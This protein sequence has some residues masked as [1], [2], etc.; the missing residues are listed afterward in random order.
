MQD[1]DHIIWVFDV[2]ELL[3]T[4]GDQFFNLCEGYY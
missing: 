1:L 3:L 2:Q 4:F